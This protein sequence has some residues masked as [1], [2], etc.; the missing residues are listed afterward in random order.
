MHV[1]LEVGATENQIYSPFKIYKK[2]TQKHK[3][4]KT[5]KHRLFVKIRMIF[6]V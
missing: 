3:N 5:Q 4:T 6:S 1:T 2:K